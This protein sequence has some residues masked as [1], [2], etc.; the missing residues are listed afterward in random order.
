MSESAIS[1][2]TKHTEADP[3]NIVILTAEH[4]AGKESYS[5]SIAS[6]L[7]SRYLEVEELF[8][9]HKAETEQEV[10]DSLRLVSHYP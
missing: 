3:V 10:I 7:I 8:V 9:L 5:H 6:S 2:I 4:G 1:G